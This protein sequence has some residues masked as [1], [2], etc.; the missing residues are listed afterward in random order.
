MFPEKFLERLASQPYID[1]AGLTAALQRPAG[2]SVRVNPRKWHHPVAGYE[3]VQWEPNGY[4]LPGKP[5]FAPD[6]LFHAGVYYPQESSGMFTGELFRQMTEGRAGLRVLDLCGA[7]GGKSTH[8]SSLIGDDGLLVANE[9][10][11]SRAAVLAENVTKWG[12][13]NT[14]VTQS[15]PSRFAAFPG[16][17][18]VIVA[19]AP[20]SGEGMFRSPV[21]VQEW[22][23]SNTR[24]CSERQ[25]RIVMEAWQAL[26]PGGIFIYSTCT[27]NPAENEHNVSWLGENTGAESLAADI[28]GMDGITEIRHSGVTGYGFHPGRVRGEG[29]FIAALRKPSKDDDD[30]SPNNE[31]PGS[32]DRSFGNRNPGKSGS[33]SSGS[34]NTGGSESR[35]AGNRNPGSRES[36]NSHAGMQPSAKAYE[37]AE[38]LASFGR[39]R[40]TISDDRIIALAAD[41]GLMSQISGSLNVVKYGTMIGEIKNGILI[42]AH[43]L[44]MSVRR[45]PGLFPEHNLTRDEALAYLRLEPIRPERMPEGRVLV[46]YRGVALGFVN[47]LGS[48]VNNGY[49]RQW[50]LR[51]AAPPDYR[52]IL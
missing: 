1:A 39:E 27:F 20:C 38:S 9:V 22:S 4:H 7:P 51:M 10:I 6:P 36:R 35:R 30:E 12:M 44:A 28:K 47:N 14:V 32:G 18:D 13:G 48:R 42:P 37:V 33:R 23:L 3:R 49:P 19:D 31:T 50:R 21:A 40:L 25:R 52:E 45:I 2:Q 29:F 16:F 8:L 26:R 43:D 46:R 15:D 41:S 24:L 5:L 11:G 34:R 17:F